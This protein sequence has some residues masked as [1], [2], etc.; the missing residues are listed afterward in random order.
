MATSPGEETNTDS[1]SLDERNESV[2]K[3]ISPGL[4]AK[5][6]EFFYIFHVNIIL[7]IPCKHYVLNPKCYS[8]Q[9]PK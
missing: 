2:A 9:D 8:A 4:Q 7:H 3:R 5:I 1:H 6:S